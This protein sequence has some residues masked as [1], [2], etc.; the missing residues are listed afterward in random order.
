[1]HKNVVKKHF[2]QLM[3]PENVMEDWPPSLHHGTTGSE[4]FRLNFCGFIYLI[5]FARV[6][7][8]GKT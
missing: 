4:H 6:H 1:M 8:V 2:F 7:L 3:A 5:F